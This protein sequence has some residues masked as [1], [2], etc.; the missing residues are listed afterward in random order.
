MLVNTSSLE[1]NQSYR[2]QR[3]SVPPL[4]ADSLVEAAVPREGRALCLTGFAEK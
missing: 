1:Q 2:M 4:K 3:T